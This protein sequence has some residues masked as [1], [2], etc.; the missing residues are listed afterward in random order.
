MRL[1]RIPGMPAHCSAFSNRLITDGFP[2][3]PGIGDPAFSAIEHLRVAF[4]ALRAWANHLPVFNLTPFIICSVFSTAPIGNFVSDV[5]CAGKGDN[6]NAEHAHF[7]RNAQ[8]E[9][10]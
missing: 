6:Y 2:A 5:F 8:K 4:Y 1:R 9:G 10:D 7:D 3:S